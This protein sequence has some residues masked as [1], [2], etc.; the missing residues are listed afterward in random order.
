[1]HNVQKDIKKDSS[2]TAMPLT[3]ERVWQELEYVFDPEI[4]LDIK[5]LGLVYEVQL[6][7]AEVHVV[8]TLTTMGCPAQQEI[9]D[10]VVEVLQ[11]LPG[12]KRVKVIWTFQPPWTPERLSEEGR[13]ILI[14]LGYL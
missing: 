12:V 8:M 6:Q 2:L 3:E 5:N 7:G 14:A 4:G 9:E 11:Q 13:D 1:M 10:Q